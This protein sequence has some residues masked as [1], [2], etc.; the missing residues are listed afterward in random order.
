[1]DEIQIDSVSQ[2]SSA[3]A[4][5]PVRNFEEL[6][7]LE[8][9]WVMI[10]HPFSSFGALAS[11]LAR[12]ASGEVKERYYVA[13]IDEDA[14]DFR[15]WLQQLWSDLKPLLGMLFALFITLFASFL[16]VTTRQ[17][18]GEGILNFG[19]LLMFVGSVIMAVITARNFQI[20]RLPPLTF[21]VS[22]LPM[23][24]TEP[25]LSRYGLRLALF[26]VSLLWT[27]GT[28]LFTAE[29]NFGGVGM[30]CWVMSILNLCR[31][32]VQRSLDGFPH[33]DRQGHFNP[34]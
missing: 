30:F 21:G 22:P 23:Q 25:F 29:N 31:K 7:L 18:G 24:S 6:T 16:F 32:M 10:R 4:V 20:D 17:D 14:F 3:A 27:F 5:T 9:L 2:E 28:W 34:L 19:L 1:M 26:G 11:T 8:M 33:L 13:E 12:P 15:L